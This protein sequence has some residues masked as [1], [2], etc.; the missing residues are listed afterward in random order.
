MTH[1]IGEWH[2]RNDEDGDVVMS[3]DHIQ[4]DGVESVST[5]MPPKNA[6]EFGRAVV[7]IAEELIEEEETS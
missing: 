4:E 3:F 1:V 5:C 2:V 6:L 7:Q